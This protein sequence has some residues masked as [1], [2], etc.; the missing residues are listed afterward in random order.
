MARCHFL[1]NFKCN[2]VS[3][4]VPFNLL[5]G[6]GLSVSP[7]S[8]L[9]GCC[10][11][12]PPFQASSPPGGWDLL[13]EAAGEAAKMRLHKLQQLHELEHGANVPGHYFYP[14]KIAASP[15]P[16][17]KNPNS[18]VN[19]YPHQSLSYQQ[20]LFDQVCLE[21][22]LGLAVKRQKLIS[23]SFRYFIFVFVL[24]CSS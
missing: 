10:Q 2:E 1:R 16:P 6:R 17:A 11:A 18:D 15:V 23:L 13:R 20:M 21:T 4:S 22:H 12:P 24:C 8:T 5:Q 7:Q 19:S 14:R 3:L 9:C